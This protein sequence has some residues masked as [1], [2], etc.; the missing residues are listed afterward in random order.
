MVAVSSA[1]AAVVLLKTI[2]DALGDRLTGFELMSRICLDGVVKYFPATVEPFAQRHDWQVLIQLS[3]TMKLSPIEEALSAA[4]QPALESGAVLD[5]VIASSDSQAK[6]MWRIREQIPEAEKREGKSVKHDIALPI[7]RIGE[8]INIAAPQLLAAFPNAQVICFGHKHCAPFV[9][10]PG[11][12]AAP[13]RSAGRG[14]L[15]RQL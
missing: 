4:L 12:S 15:Q 6:A 2:R 7:S 5:A 3:D 10:E 9:P 13:Q 1:D 8:F 11:W 14:T